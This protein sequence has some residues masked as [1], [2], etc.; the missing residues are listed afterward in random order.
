[1]KKLMW[2]YTYWLDYGDLDAVLE[3]FADDARIE[4]AMRGG[5][6]DGK[7]ALAGTYES[8]PPWSERC[9]ARV[10]TTWTS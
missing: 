10:G 1:V 4:V 9:G 2:N 3:C 5:S 8:P 7:V 6:G